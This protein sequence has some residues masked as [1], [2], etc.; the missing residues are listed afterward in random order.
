MKTS[1]FKTLALCSLAVPLN[2]QTQ[3]RDT[4]QGKEIDLDEVIVTASLAND[5]IPVTYA[6]QRYPWKKRTNT[7][8]LMLRNCLQP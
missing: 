4:T 5:K 3:S 6:Q 1:I 7:K 8:K 2:A